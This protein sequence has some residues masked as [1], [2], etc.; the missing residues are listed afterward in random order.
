MKDKIFQLLKQEYAHL[1]LGNDVL[2]AQAETLAGLGLVTD[3]NISTVIASVKPFL[4]KVQKENDKRVGDAT[5]KAKAAVRKELEDEAKA[6]EERKKQEEAQKNNEVPDWYK[7]QAEEWNKKIEEL[8][9]G[10]KTL[11]D[12]LSAM[13][14][15]NDKL[16]AEKAEADRKNLIISKARELGIPQYRI[17]EGF[18]IA[19]DADE[20]AISSYLTSVANNIKSQQLPGNKNVFPHAD[21]KPEKAEVDSIAKSLVR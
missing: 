12:S 20:A 11:S 9:K 18:V 17:D 16:K 15:E 10:S 1:G 14:A 21:S 19:S 2:L 8:S 13:K 6:A 3:E 5:A 7:Q 4:E